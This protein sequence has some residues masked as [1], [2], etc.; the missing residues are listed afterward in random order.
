MILYCNVFDLWGLGRC[1][2]GNFKLDDLFKVMWL[3]C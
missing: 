1:K 2:K 3:D